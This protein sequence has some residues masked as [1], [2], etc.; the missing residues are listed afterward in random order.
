MKNKKTLFLIVL[1]VILLAIFIN[2]SNTGFFLKSSFNSTDTGI[3]DAEFDVNSNGAATYKVGIE[4][5]PGINNLEPELNIKYNNQNDNGILGKGFNLTGLSAIS[6][7][8]R[9][10]AQDNVSGGVNFDANDRFCVDGERLMAVYGIYGADGTEYRTEREKWIK[11]YS[12]GTCGV[13]PCYFVAVTKNGTTI[14]YGNSDDSRILA[15]GRQDVRIWAANKKTDRNSNF[16]TVDYYNN[17]DTGEYYPTRIDYTGNGNTSFAPQR[18]IRFDYEDRQD[19]SVSYIA[20]S[21]VEKN[22]RLNKVSTYLNDDLVKQYLLSYG[23]SEITGYSILTQIQECDADDNCLNPTIFAWNNEFSSTHQFTMQSWANESA[24]L[25]ESNIRPGDYNGDGFSDIAYVFNDSG[26][27]AIDVYLSDGSS[28]DS[29]SWYSKGDVYWSDGDFVPGDY[30]GDGVSDMAYVYN[31]SGNIAIDVYLSSRKAFSR[32]SWYTS[33][34]YWSSENQIIS[35]DFNGDGIA[36]IGYAFNDS[37]KIGINVYISNAETKQFAKSSSLS[38]SED[39][40]YDEGVFNCGDFNDDGISDI[41]Y[42]FNNSGTVKIKTYTSTGL[43]FNTSSWSDGKLTWI[44]ANL[45]NFSDYNGDGMTDISYFYNNNGNISAKVLL[46]DGTN[47]NISSWSDSKLLWGG[48]EIIK[49]G[50]YNGDGLTDVAYIFRDDDYNI[51]I[52]TY[53]S[54]GKSFTEYQ[55]VSGKGTWSNEVFLPSDYNGNGKVDIANVF[56]N[57]GKIGFN[58]YNSGE[59]G[60]DV[61]SLNQSDLLTTITNG[62]NGTISIVYKPITD[63]T[64]YEKGTTAAPFPSINVSIPY[65]VVS[66]TVVADP[67][68]GNKATSKYYYA[69]AKVN[70]QGRGWLGFNEVNIFN[71]SS[72]DINLHTKTVKHYSQ[73]FPLTGIMQEQIVSRVSDGD[74]L[75]KDILKY[76]YIKSPLSTNNSNVYIVYKDSKE[77]QSYS[78]GDYNYSLTEDYTYDSEY[79]NIINIAYLDSD[80]LDYYECFD[81][82]DAT[83]TDT[84]WYEFFPKAKK[85]TKTKSGCTNPSFDNWNS[86]TDMRFFQVGYDTAMNITSYKTWSNQANKMIEDEK[87]YDAYGNN[88]SKTDP[89]GNVVQILYDTTYNTFPI[90]TIL[91]PA[92]DGDDSLTTESAYEAKFGILIKSVDK[93]GNTIMQIPD[94]GIDGFGRVVKM[95]TINPYNKKLVLSLTRNF[96]QND[97]CGLIIETQ[98]RKDWDSNTWVWEKDFYDSLGRIYKTIKEGTDSDVYFYKTFNNEGLVEK[99]AL[100]YY[101]NEDSQY[102]TYSYNIKK[103]L[104]QTDLPDNTLTKV[105][106]KSS[107]DRISTL[108]KPN[109]SDNST[110]ETFVSSVNTIDDHGQTIEFEDVNGGETEYTYDA[111]GQKTKVVDAI[112]VEYDTTYDSLGN[113]IEFLEENTR[114]TKYKYYDTNLIES[115]TD[116]SNQK[117]YFTYDNIGRISEL[118]TYTEDYKLEKT[119]TYTYDTAENGKGL[120]ATITTPDVKYS[121]AYDY[122]GNLKQKITTLTVGGNSQD[123]YTSYEFDA[124]QNIVNITLPDSS[125]V[126]Y[127]YYPQGSISQIVFQKSKSEDPLTIAT[128]KNYTPLGRYQE[129][130]YGNGVSAYI[131]YDVLGRMTTSKTQNGSNVLR[132]FSYDWNKAAKILQIKD[133]L[134]DDVST[135]LT[136]D[137]TYDGMGYLQTASGIS[138]DFSYKYNLTGDITVSNDVKYKYNDKRKHQIS[139]LCKGSDCYNIQYNGNGNIDSKQTGESSFVKYYYDVQNNLIQVNNNQNGETTGV[140][141]YFA[142]DNTWNRVKKVSNDGTITYYISN[143]YVV[144][145]N[146]KGELSHVSYIQG[147][148]GVVASVS[149]NGNISYFNLDQIGSTT[150]ITDEN[151][152]ETEKVVYEPYG[153]VDK[154]HS[155]IN[156]E[157]LPKFTGKELDSDFNLYYFGARYYDPDL[158]V[159]TTQDP[160]RQFANPY[161]YANNDPIKN[162]DPDGRIVGIDDAIELV[163]IATVTADVA[164]TTA[165]ITTAAVSAGEAT[166]AISTAVETKAAVTSIASVASIDAVGTAVVAT[167]AVTAVGLGTTLISGTPASEIVG[168]GTTIAMEASD[169]LGSTDIMES[170][171]TAETMFSDSLIDSCD[172][173]ISSLEEEETEGGDRAAKKFTKKKTKSKKDRRIGGRPHNSARYH[174]MQ[175]MYGRTSHEIISFI[176]TTSQSGVRTALQ[177]TFDDDDILVLSGTHGD[178]RGMTAAERFALRERRFFFEDMQTVR[179]LRGGTGRIDIVDVSSFRVTGSDIDEAIRTGRYGGR[180]YNCV[181]G[182]FCYSEVR[183][184]NAFGLDRERIGGNRL[185]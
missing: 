123:F 127:T 73:D 153:N 9:T 95:N 178:T 107:D 159:F 65:Y 181:I 43:Y 118:R 42:A 33:N 136:Q 93:N 52:N 15:Q 12:K 41:G 50:D 77:S 180:T 150:L 47:F 90:K 85:V 82:V 89:L 40:W 173:E 184:N 114:S 128:Y 21:K 135:S 23:V 58:V 144:T 138:G 91:P 72:S 185:F 165:E 124:L 86:S 171:S 97:T 154:D 87:G 125:I 20:N 115:I 69:D 4:V 75:K 34:E 131:T 3:I 126:G 53:L 121:F 108:Y 167:Q 116:S 30:D 81:F 51:S 137:F 100:P 74:V 162:I 80:G 99:E 182:A 157:F 166:L 177:N 112:G 78:N 163:A 22:K 104:I 29:K 134:S 60:G 110:G 179:R 120:I 102:I 149:E 10:I 84:W 151:G 11:F 7:C 59:K 132:N 139:N 129:A 1:L 130:D 64:V 70:V 25:D 61:Y 148:K 96:V 37:G 155:V 122:A 28:F 101:E 88:I 141:N 62:L 161:I 92:K 46:S 140:E 67:Y 44:D 79:K 14:E 119:I 45:I 35:G 38:S 2:K 113:I 55:E 174:I 142:Y 168:I 24:W 170:I 68:S 27:I 71:I 111:L 54:N 175:D 66:G 143:F 164:A 109:P 160:K 57:G 105:D 26:D 76:N 156:E 49:S 16:L 18:S 158:K 17:H 152:K 103:S 94:D 133:L 32:T 63:N 56:N 8:P 145:E 117:Q 6:R 172:S 176:G 146:S 39:E 83:S 5:P 36:D 147:E 48:V 183:Y 106:Y 13:G 169:I 31:N 19:K 98:K